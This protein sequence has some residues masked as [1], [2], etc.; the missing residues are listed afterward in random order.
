MNYLLTGSETY[1]LR[2]RRKELEKQYAADMMNITVYPFDS[3]ASIEEIIAD[4]QTMPFFAESKVVVLEN[5]A[6]IV[7]KTGKSSDDDSSSGKGSRELDMLLNYLSDPNP[8]TVMII[9]ID[10]EFS[11]SSR[12]YKQLIKKIKC[13]NFEPLKQEEF[14][15]YVKQDIND[16]SLKID[17]NAIEIMLER[18]PLSIENWKSELAKLQLYPG[19][20]DRETVKKLIAQPLED[21]VFKL[22]DG[23]VKR[24]LSKSLSIFND[25]MVRN[26]NDVYSLVGLLAYQFRFMCQ[27]KALYAQNMN[28]YDIAKQLNAKESRIKIVLQSA[29]GLSVENLL[30][31][32]NE[33][34]VLD[35]NIKQG[36]IDP[37]GGLEMFIINRC[38]KS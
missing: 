38:K 1:T 29:A 35:Q 2:A 28:Q 13:E 14:I 34:A 16:S 3:K 10:M 37:A 19:R 12:E 33:L 24:N 18:L 7:K 27:C 17:D 15:H 26:R 20:I 4:C 25:L 6:F 22:S 36:K 32:L 5:P 9:Y 11:K 31:I 30:S 8:Q 23:V 21:D